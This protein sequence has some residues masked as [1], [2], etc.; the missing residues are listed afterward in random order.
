VLTNL[1]RSASPVLRYRTGDLVRH[2]TAPCACG[3]PFMRLEG[4][5]LAR[6]D[7]MI[8]VRGV[9]VYPTAVES[10]VRAHPSIVEFRA[11]VEQDGA[12]RTLL[13]EVEV[14]PAVDPRHATA[15]LAVALRDSLGLTVQVH[16]VESGTLPR[17]EMKARRF[18]ITPA[19]SG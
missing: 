11:T 10:V 8:N 6:A 5:V 3:R 2:S 17:F 4:G 16:A 12:L 13:L 7:D 15:V 18:V 14:D 9:N 1:G 19:R